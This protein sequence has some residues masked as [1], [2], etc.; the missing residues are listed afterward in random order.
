M[1]GKTLPWLFAM[2]A[3]AALVVPVASS[4]AEMK[5]RLVMYA[6]K[7]DLKPVGDVD[8]HIAGTWERRGVC[9]VGKAVGTYAGAGTLDMTKGKGTADGKNTCTFED[10]STF[11]NKFTFNL[12]PLPGG[13]QKYTNGRGEFVGGTGRFEGMKG[14]FTWSGRSYAPVNEVTKG[15][16]VSDVVGKYTLAKKPVAHK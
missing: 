5:F 13:L 1:S 4:A 11:S 16:A 7:A 12:E 14:T 10:G 6:T 9:L 15:D 3:C 2:S 8:G